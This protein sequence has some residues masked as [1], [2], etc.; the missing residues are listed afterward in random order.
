MAVFDE[1]V[2]A[3][4][5]TLRSVA[6]FLLTRLLLRAGI[7]E[8]ESLSVSEFQA[9]LPTIEAGLREVLPPNEIDAV[10]SRVRTVLGR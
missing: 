7:F 8:K 1:V 3:L 5:P 2:G 4:Q 6:P 10:L 9:V